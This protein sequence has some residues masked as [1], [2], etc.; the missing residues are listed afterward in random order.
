MT[1]PLTSAF[2]RLHGARGWAVLGVA[3]FVLFVVFPVM[4]LA[5]PADSAFHVS[6]Y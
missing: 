3:G 6:A 4:N 5:V 1:G 2:T